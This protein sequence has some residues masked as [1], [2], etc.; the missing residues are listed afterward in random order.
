MPGIRRKT[1]VQGE[2]TQMVEFRLA[3][4]AILPVHRHVHEQTGYLVSGRLELTLGDARRPLTAGDSW[5]IPGGVLHHAQ[6]LEACVA[7]EVFSP[8]RED[9][10]DSEEGQ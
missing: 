1:L 5:C 10:R 6:A 9:F 8:P 7:I 3:A 4:G 2:R